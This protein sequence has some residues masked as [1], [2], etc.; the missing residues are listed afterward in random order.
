M[1]RSFVLLLVYVTYVHIIYA[2]FRPQ[3][4]ALVTIA[5][6]ELYAIGATVLAK[7]FRA[8]QSLPPGTDIVLLQPHGG[9]ISHRTE[10]FL[11]SLG[12][13]TRIIRLPRIVTDTF[14]FGA[15][16]R[17]NA[18]GTSKIALFNL[19]EYDRVLYVD[20]DA[21]AVA[22]VPIFFEDRFWSGNITGIAELDTKF[23]TMK[24]GLLALKPNRDQYLRLLELLP[25]PVDY[26]NADQGFLNKAFRDEWQNM[27]EE[28][29]IPTEWQLCAA[30]C[31]LADVKPKQYKSLYR[32]MLRNALMFDFQGRSKPWNWPR[33]IGYKQC[34]KLMPW[35]YA[36]IGVA[37]AYSLE[38]VRL[39]LE[40]FRE[41][42]LQVNMGWTEHVLVDAF[43]MIQNGTL[44][45]HYY[46][47]VSEVTSTIIDLP[48]LRDVQ[49][50][51][52][53][54]EHMEL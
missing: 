20:A 44:D 3:R 52:D 28:H 31:V 12:G 15:D 22:P 29:R 38:K 46:H 8:T 6:N 48:F 33:A 24:G 40:E 27:S 9:D 50:Q 36:W 49:V 37:Y 39:V 21:M 45:A 30:Y 34:E 1:T 4:N 32:D 13:F 53:E 41:N 42:R 10:S 14:D 7:S 51:V 47:K 43:N 2:N 26:V 16:K 25:G 18:A 11:R 35:V 17:M 5:D 54:D 23:I 19:T